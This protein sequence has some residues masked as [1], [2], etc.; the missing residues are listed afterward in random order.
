MREPEDPLAAIRRNPD[1]TAI[2]L[3]FDGSLSEIVE[4]PDLARPVEGVREV[5]GDLAAR[6]LLVAMV[7]G[8]PTEDLQRLLGV[9]SVRY[10]GHY[11][12]LVDQAPLTRRARERA[13]A[14]ARGLEGVWVED[15]GESLAV[16]YRLAADP[17]AARAALMGSLADI[18]R[19]EGLDLIEGKMVLELV[20]GNASRKGEAVVRLVREADAAAALFAGDDLAD[21]EAFRALDGLRREGVAVVKVAVRGRETPPALMEAADVAVDGPGGLVDLLRGLL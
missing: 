13:A 19:G 10:A 18:A 8:R 12:R 9:P 2:L 3:D 11:G 15:K 4:H 20:Q 6:Y 7:S 1:R 21:L 17:A 16:H 14:A 5:L